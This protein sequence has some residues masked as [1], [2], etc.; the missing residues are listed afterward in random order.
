MKPLHEL[1]ACLVVLARAGWTPQECDAA[2]LQQQ[3]HE[4]EAQQAQEGGLLRA[5]EDALERCIADGTAVANEH[6]LR[7][8]RR[9]TG[10]RLRLARLAEAEVYL[11]AEI[12][13]QLW[14]AQHRQ[15]KAETQRAAA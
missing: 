6:W 13:R 10:T 11:R 8:Q 12:E 9:A 2:D 5:A 7:T 14:H 3:L 15:A 1:A 4:L